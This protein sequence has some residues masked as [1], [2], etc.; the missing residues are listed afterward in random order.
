MKLILSVVI[1]VTSLAAGS[2]ACSCLPP[3]LDPLTM[4]K[5]CG[6]DF[7]IGAH[8]GENDIIGDYRV[9]NAKLLEIVRVKASKS[10]IFNN[11]MLG[12]DMEIYTPSDSA[13]CGVNFRNEGNYLLAG[14]VASGRATIYSCTT[15]KFQEL[16]SEEEQLIGKQCPHDCLDY[17]SQV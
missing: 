4:E 15:S 3:Y 13:R 10:G 14:N 7:V 1:L 16:T 2:E 6:Y 8:L 12:E 17:I 9:Y 11:I 5:Y